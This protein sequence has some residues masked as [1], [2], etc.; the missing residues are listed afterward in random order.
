LRAADRRGGDDF[1]VELAALAVHVEDGAGPR[2]GNCVLASERSDADDGVPAFAARNEAGFPPALYILHGKGAKIAGRDHH[3]IPISPPSRSPA[4]PSPAWKF[5]NNAARLF[6]KVSLNSAAR[7]RLCLRRRRLEK[8]CRGRE[9]PA[10][11]I[12]AGLPVGSA[13]WCKR[14]STTIQKDFIEQSKASSSAIH[15]KIHPARRNGSKMHMDK[16]LKYIDSERRS[17]AILMR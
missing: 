2:V 7:T 13:S 4:A 10:L 14:P 1:A 12:K 16:V 9:E 15:S 17:G 5:I 3:A 8:N 11:P 6:K